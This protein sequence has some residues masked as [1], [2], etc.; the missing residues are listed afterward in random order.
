M[1]A[2]PGKEGVGTCIWETQESKMCLQLDLLWQ[3]A[4][5]Q[6]FEGRY[7]VAE[8]SRRMSL[9]VGW[10]AGS[11]Q[12]RRAGDA[13]QQRGTEGRVER[14]ARDRMLRWHGLTPK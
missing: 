1:A 12:V 7:M 14:K 10:G 2:R 11:K 8:E 5:S 6:G 9:S 3:A 4:E 13:G